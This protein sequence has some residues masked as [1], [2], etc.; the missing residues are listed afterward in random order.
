MEMNVFFAFSLPA[1]VLLTLAGNENVKKNMNKNNNT[2][3][4]IK[5]TF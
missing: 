4:K 2:K 1:S 5:K 3:K